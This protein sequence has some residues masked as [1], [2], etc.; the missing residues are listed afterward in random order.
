MNDHGRGR[1]G[2][3]G[4]GGAT[5]SE[6]RVLGERQGAAAAALPA[7]DLGEG[8]GGLGDI[9]VTVAGSLQAAAAALPLNDHGGG[10]DGLGDIQ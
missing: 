4:I 1:D 10:R 8:Q 5:A 6:E 2:L 9:G 3:V 7:N